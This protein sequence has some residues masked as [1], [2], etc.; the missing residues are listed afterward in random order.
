[1]SFYVDQAQPQ[2]EDRRQTQKATMSG[3]NST[4]YLG[5]WY[6]VTLPIDP[7]AIRS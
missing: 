3:Y 7:K 5:F 6:C 4:G 1:M 2:M